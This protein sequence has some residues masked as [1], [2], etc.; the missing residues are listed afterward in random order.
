MST[1]YANRKKTQAQSEELTQLMPQNIDA[2]EAILG[3]I[4]VSPTCMNKVV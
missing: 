2:E 1:S 3:A 4:L